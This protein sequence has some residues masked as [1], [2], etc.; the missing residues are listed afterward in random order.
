MYNGFRTQTMDTIVDKLAR[1]DPH[2]K[3]LIHARVGAPQ[4]PPA[5]KD[6]ENIYK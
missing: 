6:T 1:G 3:K 5:F 2:L 4:I